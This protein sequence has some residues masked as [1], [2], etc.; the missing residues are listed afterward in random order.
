MLKQKF[1]LYQLLSMEIE[2]VTINHIKLKR[3]CSVTG[4]YC[5]VTQ[6]S[7]TLP[8]VCDKLR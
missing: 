6:G 2:K 3:N 5:A 1:C 4:L 7:C 8:W